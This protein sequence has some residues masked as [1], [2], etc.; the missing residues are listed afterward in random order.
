VLLAS[1][2]N[3][4]MNLR[5]EQSKQNKTVDADLQRLYTKLDAIRN[6]CKILHSKIVYTQVNVINIDKVNELKG[7]LLD[8]EKQNEELTSE[9]T[10][11]RKIKADQLREIDNI[12]GV[13]NYPEQLKQLFME[14]KALRAEQKKRQDKINSLKN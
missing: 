12:N 11:L 14:L 9:V 6:D 7:Q 1:K 2:K 13:N 3:E 4:Q 5:R 10:S 8:L